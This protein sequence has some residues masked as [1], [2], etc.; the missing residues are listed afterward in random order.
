MRYLTA[1]FFALF[2]SFS[3][4]AQSSTQRLDAFSSDIIRLV[5]RQD[6]AV[7]SRR[8]VTQSQLE[9]MFNTLMNSR[10]GDK[11]MS[12]LP[13][14][15]DK[16]KEDFVREL[17][18]KV[19]E[20][21]DSLYAQGA[22]LGINWAKAKF[23]DH[24]YEIKR[25]REMPMQM[26]TDEIIFSAA[27]SNF[28][29]IKLEGAWLENDWRAGEIKQRIDVLNKQFEKVRSGM[30]EV[31]DSPATVDS[32]TAYPDTSAMMPAIEE[33]KEP[34]P[35][36]PPVKKSPAKKKSPARKSSPAKKPK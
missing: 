26:L 18:P 34:A 16:V 7:F 36:K 9:E 19:Y 28:Y 27:D 10:M 17:L 23:E 32:T 24:F 4:S 21:L 29:S 13:G 2:L 15:I 30:E 20:R 5:S 3:A 35:P 14:G 8:I 22:R 12:Q 25:E 1:L 33:M 31:Y 6:T 11:I